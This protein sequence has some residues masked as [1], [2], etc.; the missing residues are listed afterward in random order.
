MKTILVVDDNPANL[1]ILFHCLDQDGYRTLV[2]Q[3]G[4][5]A[6]KMAKRTKPDLILLDIV[7]PEMDGYNTCHILKSDA[8]TRN[9]PIIFITALSDTADKVAGFQAGAVDYI[10]KPFQQEEILARI[11][12]H[13]MLQD[14]KN[15][16]LRINREKEKILSV[17]AH[18]LKTPF[19]SM[20]G[21]MGLLKEGYEDYTEKERKAF[22]GHAHA[23]TVKVYEML[24]KLLEWARSGGGFQDCQVERINLSPLIHATLSLFKE[25]A[26]KKDIRIRGRIPKS[27]HI[28]A[29]ANMMASILRNLLSNAIKFTEPGGTVTFSAKKKGNQAEIRI[30]DTGT[31]MREDLLENLLSGSCTATHPGTCGE[32]GTGLGMAICLEFVEKNNGILSAQSRPG[33]GST[34]ILRFPLS[35]AFT[36]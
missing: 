36:K 25:S 2:A 19:G 26:E 14:Q 6:F 32:R 23:S 1:G 3:D 11:R 31:G 20:L 5:T 15:Q 10:C 13:M 28:A 30:A 27:L 9:I 29:D 12:L 33:G 22:I 21:F 18:D 17:V 8:E 16:L 7:M 35:P 24:E 4:E 34:F